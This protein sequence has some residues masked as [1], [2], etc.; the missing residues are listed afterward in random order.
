MISSFPFGP[1][2]QRTPFLPIII[3]QGSTMSEAPLE[4]QDPRHRGGG[5][6][7]TR[8][9]SA[10]HASPVAPPLNPSLNSPTP[11]P[12]PPSQLRPSSLGSPV[13]TG[14]ETQDRTLSGSVSA[15]ASPAD[16]FAMDM[17][18]LNEQV[19]PSRITNRHD[20]S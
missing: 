4:S 1:I 8:Y 6:G 3:A 20:L 15:T 2:N 7:H 10:S 13:L 12:S 9:I 11:G 19:S 5:G 17:T 14:L 18:F 16:S